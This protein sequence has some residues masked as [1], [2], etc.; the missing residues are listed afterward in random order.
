MECGADALEHPVLGLAGTGGHQAGPGEAVDGQLD[1]DGGFV[2]ADV[3]RRQVAEGV[4]ERLCIFTLDEPGIPRTGCPV[5][6]GEAVV[7][8]VTSG[9]LSP[10]LDVGIGMAYVRADLAAAGTALKIDIRGK[11][12]AATTGKRP[13]VDTSPKKE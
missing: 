11:H 3:M 13:L 1:G 12:K 6:V 4:P 10:T 2:G 5:M 8:E 7:G 9:T